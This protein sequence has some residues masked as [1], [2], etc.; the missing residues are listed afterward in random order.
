[1]RLATLAKQVR[2]CVKERLQAQ[3][4][5][6]LVLRS[7]FQATDRGRSARSAQPR[8]ALRQRHSPGFAD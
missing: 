5:D 2:K 3:P 6:A 7:A 4:A 1:M 8:R